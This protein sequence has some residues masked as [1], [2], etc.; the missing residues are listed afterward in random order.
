MC[1]SGSGIA[2]MP[3]LPPQLMLLLLLLLRPQGACPAVP[4][5]PKPWDT[6]GPLAACASSTRPCAARVH[7]VD[8]LRLR[9]QGHVLVRGEHPL[10]LLHP[11]GSLWSRN[12]PKADRR[13][14]GQH[15]SAQPLQPPLQPL[16]LPPPLIGSLSA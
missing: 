11:P 16:L 7:E 13:D 9:T 15:A 14:P 12:N 10:L 5:L 3:L 6:A 8:P 4:Q 2:V 1:G